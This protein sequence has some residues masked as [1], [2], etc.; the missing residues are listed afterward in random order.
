MVKYIATVDVEA[1]RLWAHVSVEEV[2]CGCAKLLQDA[3]VLLVQPVERALGAIAGD[4][5]NHLD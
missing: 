3:G 2:V 5:A 1:I 4:R